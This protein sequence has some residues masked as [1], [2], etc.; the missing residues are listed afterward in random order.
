MIGTGDFRK[1]PETKVEVKPHVLPA[2]VK[3]KKQKAVA[4]VPQKVREV[5]CVFDENS[6]LADTPDGRDLQMIAGKIT[7]LTSQYLTRHTLR[8]ANARAASQF[9]QSAVNEAMLSHIL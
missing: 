8:G 6:R 2:V 7:E 3:A 1:K 4:K 9:L 5:N